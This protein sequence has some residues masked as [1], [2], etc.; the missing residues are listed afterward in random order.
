ML[1]CINLFFDKNN[2]LINLS[3]YIFIIILTL[4]IN[5]ILVFSFYDYKKIVELIFNNELKNNMK[6]KEGNNMIKITKISK[7][8]IH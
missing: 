5:S 7:T 3:K 1:S 2:I 8:K 4:S 6:I